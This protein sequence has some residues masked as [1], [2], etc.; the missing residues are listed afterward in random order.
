[1]PEF[2]AEPYIYLP[3]VTHRSALVAWGVR[4]HRHVEGIE[5]VAARLH[6]IAFAAGSLAGA[7]PGGL[8]ELAHQRHGHHEQIRFR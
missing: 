3:T 4:V 5:S 1:M 2:H 6:S 7:F 8:D